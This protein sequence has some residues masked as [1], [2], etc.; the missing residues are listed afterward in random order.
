VLVI[1]S[2]VVNRTEFPK[3]S[4]D[5]IPGTVDHRREVPRRNASGIDKTDELISKLV[6]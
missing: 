6:N 3:E 5:Q 4:I 2:I 1:M